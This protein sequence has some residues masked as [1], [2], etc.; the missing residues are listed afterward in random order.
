MYEA[1]SRGRDFPRQ[2]GE[3][4]QGQEIRAR[5]RRINILNRP[6]VLPGV[7]VVVASIGFRFVKIL[8]WLAA[9]AVLGIA[10]VS[11]ANS[12][13]FDD[14]PIVE[15]LAVVGLFGGFSL[16]ALL[17]VTSVFRKRLSRGPTATDLAEEF[18][19][20]APDS[21][22]KSMGDSYT[23]A[24]ETNDEMLSDRDDLLS[25][26]AICLVVEITALLLMVSDTVFGR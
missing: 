8:F 13:G 2:C 18:D 25:Y 5:D 9:A 4:L 20:L 14:P 17:A 6:V 11:F 3:S 7:C 12:E 21:Y 10:L 1:W 26:A 23:K 24:L 15:V 22:L 16:I 19:E